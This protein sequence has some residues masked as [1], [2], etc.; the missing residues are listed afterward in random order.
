[1]NE[2]KSSDIISKVKRAI[3]E[4]LPSGTPSEEE[5]AR[6]VFVSSRTLQ[7]KL[8][9]ENTNFRTLLLEVRRKLAERYIADKTMPL[10]EISYMLGFSETSSFSRA[11][12]QWTGTTP[13]TFRSSIPA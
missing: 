4:S 12:K 5:I 11:F 8:A 6:Q 2:L 9:D 10:V 3:I 1:M 7:R 13:A